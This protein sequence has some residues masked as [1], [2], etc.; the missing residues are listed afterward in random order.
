MC[1][2]RTVHDSA[3]YK[4]SCDDYILIDVDWKLIVA[5]HSTQSERSAN[6]KY[7]SGVCFVQIGKISRLLKSHDLEC[8]QLE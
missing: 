6:Q 8:F 2:L 7:E 3:L 4:K 5:I 1:F